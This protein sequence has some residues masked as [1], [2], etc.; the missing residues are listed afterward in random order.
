MHR[1]RS[2]PKKQL[3]YNNGHGHCTHRKDSLSIFH[4]TFLVKNICKYEHELAL[5]AIGHNRAS[6]FACHIEELPKV[7]S[8]AFILRPGITSPPV[9]IRL[10]VDPILHIWP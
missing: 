5:R 7:T 9:T 3:C 2:P 10:A 1:K 8:F 4:C 6:S